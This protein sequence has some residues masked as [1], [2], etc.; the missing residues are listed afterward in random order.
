MNPRRERRLLKNVGGAI[1]GDSLALRAQKDSGTKE[2]TGRTRKG[3][4]GASRH[5]VKGVRALTAH[6]KEEESHLQ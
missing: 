2:E 5:E 6:A 1:G 3:E 4:A